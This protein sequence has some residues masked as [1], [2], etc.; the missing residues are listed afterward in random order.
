MYDEKKTEVV[1]KSQYSVF[2][3]LQDEKSIHKE[4]RGFKYAAKHFCTY[5]LVFFFGKDLPLEMK[6]RNGFILR[7]LAAS[8]TFI[9]KD[10]LQG[11]YNNKLTFIEDHLPDPDIDCEGMK[12]RLERL[13]PFT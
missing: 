6:N 12:V 2:K 11:L 3:T 5:F 10:D 13:N 9:I 4:I 7:G 8:D 1:H